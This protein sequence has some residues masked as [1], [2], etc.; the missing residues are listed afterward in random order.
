MEICHERSVRGEECEVE[1]CEVC[2]RGRGVRGE[3]CEVQGVR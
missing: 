1:I 3:G 2:E